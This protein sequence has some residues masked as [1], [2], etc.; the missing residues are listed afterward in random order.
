MIQPN[1]SPLKDGDKGNAIALDDVW[2]PLPVTSLT[3]PVARYA[4]RIS[5]VDSGFSVLPKRLFTNVDL[6]TPE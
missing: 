6:P 4:L 5:E 1:S 2:R 3:S